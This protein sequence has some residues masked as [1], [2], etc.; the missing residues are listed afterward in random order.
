MGLH[1]ELSGRGGDQVLVV[2]GLSVAAGGRGLL[3][4]FSTVAR[5]GDRIAV[6][7]PNGIG[8][9]TLLATLLGDW[10]ASEGEVRRGAGITPAWFRQD[11][12]HLPAN[13]TI[14]DCVADARPTWNRGQVQDHLGRFGFSGDEVR[15]NTDS[16]SGGE[17][18]RVA[19]ALIT[20]QGSNLLALDEPTNH[21][22]VESIEAL[23]DALEGY[24][25]TVL[26]VSHDRALL[27]KATNRVWAFREGALVDYPGP[28]ADWEQKVATEEEERI[29]SRLEAGREAREAEKARARKA[30]ESRRTKEAPLREARRRVE[31]LEGEVHAAEAAV[32]ELEKA[33]AH[34][35]LYDGSPESAR[36]AG[37]LT[38]DLK[39]A[40]EALDA[41]MLRWAEGVEALENL[42]A[43]S[44]EEP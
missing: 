10:P 35:D 38:I 19:L 21:L 42:T 43:R 28:F 2:E 44:T 30:A 34:P 4:G 24:P 27:R 5:R 22:D 16:L 40:R 36:E 14:F 37:R 29:R 26:L 17:R 33:L 9:T 20:L 32:K 8:K 11:H 15:R 18:A 7:G 39:E 3:K 23:E 31:A 25:G 12:A 13:K 41:V 6:V 1:F